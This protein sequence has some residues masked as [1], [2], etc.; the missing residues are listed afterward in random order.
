M[1]PASKSHSQAGSTETLRNDQ[2]EDITPLL[3]ELPVANQKIIFDLVQRIKDA[4]A[5]MALRRL[6][7]IID[8]DGESPI[9]GDGNDAD[10]DGFDFFRG[11]D[12]DGDDGNGRGD[13]EANE[14]MGDLYRY[15]HGCGL[16]ERKES[17][18]EALL[19]LDFSIDSDVDKHDDGGKGLLGSSNSLGGSE[20]SI[21]RSEDE[22]LD[23]SNAKKKKR[24]GVKKK[25]SKTK[26]KDKDTGK[27]FV[28]EKNG[29][30]ANETQQPVSVKVNAKKKRTS[31]KELSPPS[32]S[33]P[34]PP[35]PPLPQPVP[36]LEVKNSSKE[37]AGKNKFLPPITY[38]RKYQEVKPV[39][40]QAITSTT[41]LPP[42][43]VQ[44]QEDIEERMRAILR[45]YPRSTV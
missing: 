8:D 41:M 7:M 18:A 6:Q 23:V 22:G 32:L 16:G 9:G 2:A 33:L 21:Q 24:E 35:P 45:G 15:L 20:Y 3:R 26:K 29:L 27:A 11:G 31:E 17:I 39:Y 36:K 1:S 38:P 30:G 19:A 25:G 13:N 10:E 44:Q 14:A 28:V 34:L 4:Y 37:N 42:Q 40:W 12:G 5:D 43:I